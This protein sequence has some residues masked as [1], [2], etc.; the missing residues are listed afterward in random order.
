MLDMV[1][2]HQPSMSCCR[3]LGDYNILG[4]AQTAT[5][6]AR[7]GLFSML[8]VCTHMVELGTWTSL[9]SSARLHYCVNHRRVMRMLNP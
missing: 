1:Q 4:M 9:Q 5:E 3:V 8:M 6:G 7:T 2:L